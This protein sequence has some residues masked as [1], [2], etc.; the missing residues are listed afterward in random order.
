MT[1]KVYYD[2]REQLDQYSVGFPSTE[3]GV[4]LEILQAIFTE[5]EA[6]MYLNL[7]MMLESPEHL[8]K[9]I[10][11]ETP[12]V[13]ALLERM[14][15]KGQIFRTTKGD[16]R[17]Y[18]AAPFIVGSYEFQVKNMDRRFAELFE[19]YFTEA[20][21]KQGIS[22]SA[23]LR[24]VPVNKTIDH[25]WPVAPYED[26]K[27]IIKSKDT[28]SVGKCICRTQQN[29]LDKGCGK[30]LEACLQFGSHA[31]FYV[32]KGMGRYITQDEAL[33]ILEQ[34]DK[35]GLVPQPF[36]SQDTGGICNCCGDCCGIL[37]SIKFHPKPSERVYTNYYAQADPETCSGCET[38]I[39]RCQMEAIRIDDSGVAIVDRDRC[40]GCGLCVTTCPADAMSLQIKPESERKEPPKTSKEFVMN[41]A[42]ARGKS[43]IPLSVVKKV[44]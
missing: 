27:E 13:A 12:E 40:I 22:Q 21:G 4:E 3:S 42:S 9:R 31:H 11:R 19:K 18:A 26:L 15:E 33:S 1:A 35:D 25:K 30:T 16:A 37:R 23:P 34:C 44:Q 39:G 6:E 10:G 32:D 36:I 43:L 2:L 14:V 41:L 28:I 29:L 17:K 20:F 24:T 38:C 7:S 5:E 8:A